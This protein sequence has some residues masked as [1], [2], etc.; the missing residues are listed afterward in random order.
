MFSK[1]LLKLIEESIIPAFGFLF[2]KVSVTLYLANSLG[3]KADIYNL[4]SL[5]VSR[6]HFI[7]INS[8][9]LLLF[10]LFCFLG[11]VYSL[12]KSLYFHRSHIHPRITLGLYN[13]RA[14]FLIQDS[15]H[16]FSQGLIWLIF[17]YI[18][19]IIS[20]FL[21][22]L[23]L[24]NGYVVILNLILTPIATYFFILDIENEL[25][26]NDEDEEVYITQ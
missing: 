3:Y 9:I 26:Q 2:L 21:F 5:Q 19:L 17:S 25:E 1:I 16:L 20:S 6:E 10:S 12:I 13:L 8:Y 24:I 15:F 18:G 22:Y 14:N 7:I 11:I 23:N 4:F